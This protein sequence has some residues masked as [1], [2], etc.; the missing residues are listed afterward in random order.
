MTI[1]GGSTI[2]SNNSSYGYCLIC[3]GLANDGPVVLYS[4]NLMNIASAPTP[5]QI[6]ANLP[7]MSVALINSPYPGSSFAAT[8]AASGSSVAGRIVSAGFSAT[9]FGSELYKGGSFTRFVSANHDNCAT[10]PFSTIANFDEAAITRIRD[11]PV[12]V[13]AAGVDDNELTY[14]SQPILDQEGTPYYTNC[15]YPYSSGQPLS[16]TAVTSFF[17]YGTNSSAAIAA[18]SI[19]VSIINYVGTVGAT[20]TLNFNTV[21]GAVTTVAYTAAAFTGR[22]SVVFT[23]AALATAISAGAMCVG[24]SHG[25]TGCP[26]AIGASPMVLLITPA[27]ASSTNANVFELEYVQ[28]AEFIGPATSALHTPTHSDARGFEI[29]NNVAQRLPAALAANHEATPQSV[30]MQLLRN[31]MIQSAPV[32]TEIGSRA[33]GA[34]TH[35]AA[36]T[37]LGVF[38]RLAKAGAQRL[39]GM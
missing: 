10:I 35:M 3:P 8:D 19:T 2:G 18:T 6:A 30:G 37:A 29:V 12:W 34:A 21:G 23:V 4:N 38:G 9:Y 25:N 36:S 31:V 14:N 28:H 33:I 15:I 17:L 26:Y 1:G 27:N 20:G 32:V 11:K 13:L 7:F 24:Y 39:I 22:T 16:T 5:A